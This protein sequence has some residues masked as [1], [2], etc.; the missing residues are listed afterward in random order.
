MEMEDTS[1]LTNAL[2]GPQVQESTMK[3]KEDGVFSPPRISK[4]RPKSAPV[5]SR[6]TEETQESTNESIEIGNAA[7]QEQE[8]TI[9]SR[10]NLPKLSQILRHRITSK[11]HIKTTSRQSSRHK[12]LKNKK[13]PCT[14][15]SYLCFPVRPPMRE[16]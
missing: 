14:V 7:S 2:S 12:S 6:S 13:L 10:Y 4:K 16:L 1:Q 5:E 3:S 11:R 9:D 15:K 8:A